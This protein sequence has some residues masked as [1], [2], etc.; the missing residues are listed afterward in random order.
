MI[1]RAAALEAAERLQQLAVLVE[2][3]GVL[4][5]ILSEATRTMKQGMYGMD[6]LTNADDQIFLRGNST[7]GTS[8]LFN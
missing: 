7:R 2:D 1:S 4:K 8:R 5:R 3:D 6:K